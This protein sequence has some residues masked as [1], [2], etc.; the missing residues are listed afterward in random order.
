MEHNAKNTLNVNVGV[1]APDSSFEQ[2]ISDWE[3]QIGNHISAHLIA[4]DQNHNY[5]YWVGLPATVLATIAG[6]TLLTA[7][8]TE[9]LRVIIGIITLVSAALMAIQT[10]YS[11]SKRAEMHRTAAMQFKQVNRELLMYQQFPPKSKEEQ[12]RIIDEINN[13]ISEIEKSAPIVSVSIYRRLMRDKD[14]REILQ[15]MKR[16]VP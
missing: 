1:S 13:R 6:S 9:W 5:H 2:I 7:T 10:F 16:L 14:L 15:M 12:K 11:F 8:T 4:S 3:K